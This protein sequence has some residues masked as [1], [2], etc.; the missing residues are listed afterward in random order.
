MF[1]AALATHRPAWLISSSACAAYGGA[2]WF[3]AMIAAAATVYPGVSVR[4]ILDCG[5]MPGMV[6]SGVR[7]GVKDLLF[8]GTDDARARL[9]PLAEAAGARLLGP[10]D[11]GPVLDLAE[12]TDPLEAARAWVAGNP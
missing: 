2:G 9:A 3:L 8:T 11:V 7:G 6:M 4:G 5:D 10:D 12:E 1:A